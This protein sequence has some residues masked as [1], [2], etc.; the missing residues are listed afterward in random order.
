MRVWHLVALAA[1]GH[2]GSSLIHGGDAVTGLTVFGIGIGALTWGYWS[3]TRDRA[4][5][6]QSR[7][8]G[9]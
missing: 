5:R 7:A 6:I 2:S 3:G 1:V 9:R 8:P 4:P